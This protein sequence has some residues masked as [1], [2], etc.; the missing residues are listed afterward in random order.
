MTDPT[1]VRSEHLD[2]RESLVQL[3]RRSRRQARQIRWMMV[4][5]LA[6][7]LIGLI[8]GAASQGRNLTAD[9]VE[10]RRFVVQSEDGKP[11]ATLQAEAGETSFRLLADDGRPA[12]VLRISRNQTGREVVSLNQFYPTGKPAFGFVTTAD[13]VASFALRRPDGKLL[14]ALNGKATDSLPDVE[15]GQERRKLALFGA[16]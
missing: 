15:L 3:E 14:I 1:S 11:R 10:A 16:E 4:A 6:L 5:L 13:G 7:P 2:L 8:A 12:M 9:S